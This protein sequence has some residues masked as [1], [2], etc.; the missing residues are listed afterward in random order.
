MATEK[1]RRVTPDLVEIEPGHFCACHYPERKLGENGEYLFEVK[2]S[3]KTIEAE[4][5]AKV[6]AEKAEA[7]Q[8]EA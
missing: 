7:E 8:A 1:C 3:T 6:A 2:K 5:D 4:N